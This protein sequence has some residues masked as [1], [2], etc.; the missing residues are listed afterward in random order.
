[1]ARVHY[2]DPNSAE[3][4]GLVERIVAERGGVLHL[5]QMLLHSPPITEGWL[6]LLTAV[7]QQSTLAGALRELVIMRIAILN[8]AP[9]EAEQHTP[10][11]LKAGL[12]RTQ[13]DALGDWAASRH[14]TEAQRGVLAL[15]DAMTRDVHVDEAVFDAVRPHLSARELVELV[16]TVAAYNMVSRVLEAL[17]IKSSDP[18]T[19]LNEAVSEPAG[20]LTRVNYFHGSVLGVDEFVTEQHYLRA[21]LRRRNRHLLGSGVVDGLSVALDGRAGEQ[22]ATLAPGLAIDARGEEIEIASAV[23]LALPPQGKHL[24]VQINY[25]ERLLRPV[26]V[27]TQAGDAPQTRPS[28][29]EESFRAYVAPD[30]KPVAVTLARLVFARSKWSIDRKYKV[31]RVRGGAS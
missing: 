12:S 7:R 3:T 14:F 31:P 8:G 9:Y 18:R 28:R 16:V 13:L 1:M 19:A 26:P 17:Q 15:T 27:V 25:A 4:R 10:I 23:V 20:G 5:Y 2:A 22:T 11:A 30:P 24:L 29:V 21:R 6:A